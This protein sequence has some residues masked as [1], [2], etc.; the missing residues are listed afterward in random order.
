VPG[1][2]RNT[3]DGVVIEALEQYSRHSSENRPVL[4][5]DFTVTMDAGPK[6]AYK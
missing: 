4:N 3:P 1:I 5:R 2:I 6:N